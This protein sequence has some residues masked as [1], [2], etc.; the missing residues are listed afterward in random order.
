MESTLPIVN[1]FNEWDPLEE[2]IVGR[3]DGARLPVWD[4]ILEGILP[5]HEAQ[6]KPELPELVE[7]ASRQLE[8]FVRILEAEGVRVRRP[9]PI[10]QSR[11][12]ASRNWSWPSGMNASNPRDLLLVVGREIIE[13]PCAMRGRYYETDAY[14]PLLREYF[15]K[16]AKWTSAPKPMLL[17][18]LYVKNFKRSEPGEPLRFPIT[19]A[20]PVFDA[21][22]FIRCGRDIFVTKSFVTNDAGITWLERHL[23][24]DYRIHR[25]DTQCRKPMHIDT[26]F[27]PLAPGKAL[28][29]PEFA[30]KLPDI[31]KKWDIL[32]APA[33][34][35]LDF[36]PTLMMSSFWLSMNVVSID[37]KRVCVDSLQEELIRKLRDWGFEPIPVPFQYVFPFGG[38]FHCATLDVRRRGTLKSYF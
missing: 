24:E 29:N 21:A 12:Y 4:P 34:I 22:D 9:E 18:D 19:E 7:P 31:L 27:V 14:R 17:D 3:V 23:G 10:D 33:P 6:G 8:E 26:T 32:Y 30:P 36:K 13:T 37:E 20:E 1:S 28:A 35:A 16:G 2:V 11:P 25:I 38:A 15:Q 5:P